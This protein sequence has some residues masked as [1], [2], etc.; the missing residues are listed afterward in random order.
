[1]AE[2]SEA[3]SNHKVFLADSTILSRCVGTQQMSLRRPIL[4]RYPA[5]KTCYNPFL[6][7]DIVIISASRHAQDQIIGQDKVS[8]IKR[9]VEEILSI[10]HN[11]FLPNIGEICTWNVRRYDLDD[12][13]RMLANAHR[14]L[15]Q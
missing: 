1:M 2:D 6:F 11:V 13:F 5:K 9:L 14:T 10:L 8:L 15:P 3:D 7:F 12:W 4:V